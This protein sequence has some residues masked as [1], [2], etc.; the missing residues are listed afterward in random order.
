MRC[1]GGKALEGFKGVLQPLQKVVEDAS[2][3]A[4][5]VVG[6]LNRQALVKIA[7]GDGFRAQRH[8]LQGL[9]R[10]MSHAVT[11]EA[12]EQ[13]RGRHGQQQERN[14][15][16]DAVLDGRGAVGQ[17]DQQMAGRRSNGCG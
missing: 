6:V 12:G 13:K 11:G 14:K 4:Q 7:G 15:L 3:V 9:Q 17:P 2:H 1:V 8:F 10:L 16:Q 5:F